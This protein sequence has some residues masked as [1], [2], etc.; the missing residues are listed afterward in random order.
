M[1]VAKIRAHILNAHQFR[2]QKTNLQVLRLVV[3]SGPKSVQFLAMLD[4]CLA[5][6]VKAFFALPP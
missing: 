4:V 3:A 1:Q 6:S 5:P 2:H